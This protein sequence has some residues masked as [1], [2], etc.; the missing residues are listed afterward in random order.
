[1]QAQGSELS[2]ATD[3][4]AVGTVLYEL[5]AGKLPFPEDSNPVAM[6][7]RHVHEEPKPLLHIAPHVPDDVASV[8]ARSLERDPAQRYHDAQEFAV[9][10]A[11]AACRS[12][13]PGWL[14]ATSM[15]VAATGP[16][17]AAATGQASR[18]TPETIAPHHKTPRE[19][20]TS[21][22]IAPADLVPVTK[23]KPDFVPISE[24]RP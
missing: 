6:L 10:V 9:A 20:P 8:T 1:E 15:T 17:L 24:L 18:A 7:Y 3:I 14:P 4:Y 11:E 5:L 2:P 23:L 13:G 21:A 12:W 16:V 19:T 22:A